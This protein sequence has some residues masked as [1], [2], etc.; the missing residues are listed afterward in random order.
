LQGFYSPDIEQWEEDNHNLYWRVDL[1]NISDPFIQVNETIYW[2]VINTDYSI[3]DDW[4][5]GWKTTNDS[6]MDTAVWTYYLDP[7]DWYNL[8]DPVTNES[9]DFSFVITGEPFEEPEEP[10][11]DNHKMHFPQLPDP[12]GWDVDFVPGGGFI[13]DDWQCTETGNVT[14]IHLWVSSNNDTYGLEDIEYAF[15]KDLIPNHRL[16]VIIFDN[17]DSHPSHPENI[18]WVFD[19]MAMNCTVDVVGPFIGDEGWFTPPDTYDE[20]NHMRY[21]RVDL[22]NFTDPFYQEE[23][24][25]YWLSVGPAPY[26]PEELGWKTSQDHFMDNATYTYDLV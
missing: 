22:T 20:H 18:L 8:S 5:I 25:I 14:D 16:V 17:N 9:I 23:G 11:W 13:A 3:M 12:D 15:G 1:E 4:L 6:F 21:W 24:V 7:P 26:G 10:T 19:G 2:L